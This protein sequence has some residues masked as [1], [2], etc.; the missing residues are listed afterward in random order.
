MND[1]YADQACCSYTRFFNKQARDK[2]PG[3]GM[4]QDLLTSVLKNYN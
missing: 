2:Q 4:L 1:F 3:L